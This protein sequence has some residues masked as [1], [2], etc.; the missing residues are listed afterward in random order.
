MSVVL[1]DDDLKRFEAEALGG[2]AGEVR[3]AS[4][5]RRILELERLNAKQEKRLREADV[6]IELQKKA[7]ELWGVKDDDTTKR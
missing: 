2:L 1:R 3:S 6:L 4:D 5:Q 7:H